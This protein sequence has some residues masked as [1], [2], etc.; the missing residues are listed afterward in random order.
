MIQFQVVEVGMFSHLGEIPLKIKIMPQ[1]EES[2]THQ[3]I[4]H[5]S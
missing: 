4:S 5:V 1:K 3:T 2:H